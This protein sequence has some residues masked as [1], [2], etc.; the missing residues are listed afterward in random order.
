MM[1]HFCSKLKKTHKHQYEETVLKHLIFDDK[2][3]VIYC[4]VP[5]A[6][7]T[8]MKT[9]FLILQGLFSLEVLEKA[10]NVTHKDYLSMT[11]SLCSS[12][13]DSINCDTPESEIKYKLQTYFKFM[14]VRNPLER[15]FSA[16]HEK[17]TATTTTELY[18]SMQKFVLRYSSDYQ[19]R[20]PN[21][22][23]FVDA[24]LE[25]DELNDHHFLPMVE[26][27]DPCMIEYDFYAS[28]SSLNHDIS[29]LLHML[30][31][32]Q[33]YYFNNIKHP[34]SLIPRSS[35]YNA[36]LVTGIYRQLDPSMREVLLRRFSEELDFFRTVYPEQS[37]LLD[38]ITLTN[39]K[40]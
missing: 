31:I 28:F 18:Q 27:C 2:H 4:Y 10:A 30:K 39:E 3:K 20:F 32:P 33:E 24:F 36:S 17:L 25:T 15:F 23:Q 38:E 26:I 14:I 5:K 11:L 16:F 1:K 21:F 8:M 22:P 19:S 29:G 12:N 6:G 34:Q 7:C 13:T 37:E 35:H 9:M 40:L